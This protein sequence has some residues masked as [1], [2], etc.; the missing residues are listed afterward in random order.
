MEKVIY[1][2]GTQYQK[3]SPKMM[4]HVAVWPFVGL[5][6]PEAFVTSQR[7]FEALYVLGVWG[8]YGEGMNFNP[9]WA[10]DARLPYGAVQQVFW[11]SVSKPEASA[12]HPFL[13]SQIR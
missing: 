5:K 10:R 1:V 3:V 8:H 13:N 11:F 2:E 6:Y 12:R 4:F 9:I 7:V